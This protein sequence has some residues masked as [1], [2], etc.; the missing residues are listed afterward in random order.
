MQ[1]NKIILM[2]TGEAAAK[3]DKIGDEQ[4]RS[5]KELLRLALSLVVVIHETFREGNKIIITTP[6]GAPLKEIVFP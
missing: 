4:C 6:E 5:R 3:L 2:L 1:D